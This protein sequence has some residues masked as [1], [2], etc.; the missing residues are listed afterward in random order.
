MYYR[1]VFLSNL[2]CLKYKYVRQRY[3]NSFVEIIALILIAKN[4]Y[5]KSMTASSI[6]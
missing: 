6:V 5:N 1:A 4:V 3:M 2:L